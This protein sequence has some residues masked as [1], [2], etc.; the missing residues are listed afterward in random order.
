MITEH[1]DYYVKFTATSDEIPGPDGM[2]AGAFGG[3]KVA[4]PEVGL[5][6]LIRIGRDGYAFSENDLIALQTLVTEM[7]NT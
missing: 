2:P 7:L 3:Q 5:P 4:D 6:Y 1:L